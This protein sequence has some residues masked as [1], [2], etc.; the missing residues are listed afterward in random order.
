MEHINFHF[1]LPLPP[2]KSVQM[3][4]VGFL[5]ALMSLSPGILLFNPEDQGEFPPD[6]TALQL[7]VWSS[8]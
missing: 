5:I 8:V 1:K 4:T 2:K 6:C 7:G 3:T